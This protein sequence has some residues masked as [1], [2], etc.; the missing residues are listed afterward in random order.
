ML[1]ISIFVSFEIGAVRFKPKSNVLLGQD[2][3][4]EGRTGLRCNGRAPNHDLPPDRTT[5]LEIWNLKFRPRL[6]G[7]CN[8]K[9]Q[10]E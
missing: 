10:D 1:Y 5:H 2:V 7:Q 9:E 8:E 3:I 4:C 6:S